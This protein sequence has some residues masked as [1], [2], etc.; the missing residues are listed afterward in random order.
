MCL[1]V[2]PHRIFTIVI[3]TTSE[4]YWGTV[5]NFDL[6]GT[7]KESDQ[8]PSR[9]MN[10]RPWTRTFSRRRTAIRPLYHLYPHGTVGDPFMLEREYNTEDSKRRTGV[11]L[12]FD[13][14]QQP[15]SCTAISYF[16]VP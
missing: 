13:S 11:L 5:A 10:Y 2:L 12:T 4:T 1:S 7:P 14:K 8:R 9:L 3:Q 6:V 15:V 16:R